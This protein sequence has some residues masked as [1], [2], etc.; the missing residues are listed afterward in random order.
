MQVH[1]WHVWGLPEDD[2]CVASAAMVLHTGTWPLLLDP[3]GQALPWL[4]G[5]E[6]SSRLQVWL[7]VVSWTC[8]WHAVLS[9]QP[10]PQIWRPAHA[11]AI[12]FRRAVRLQL[13]PVTRLMAQLQMT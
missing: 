13:L 5:L 8:A 12:C 11:G 10:T 9:W 7:H 3:Q 6:A 2:V 1:D 4:R